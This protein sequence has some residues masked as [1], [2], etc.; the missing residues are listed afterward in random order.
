MSTDRGRAA[1]R[2]AEAY[3]AARG[4]RPVQ[5]N[6]RCRAGEIDLVMRDG[7]IWVF[8]EVRL[9]RHPGFG[10]A[11]ESVDASKQR[12]LLAAARHF[13]AHHAPDAPARIDVVGLDGANRIDWV[14]GAIDG[15]S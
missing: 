7:P 14:P 9:R 6:Y 11:L 3:L 4:L 10:S 5:R 15:M 13:L 12:R 2:R 1:E 8:V